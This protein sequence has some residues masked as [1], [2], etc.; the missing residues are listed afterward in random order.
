MWDAANGREERTFKGNDLF[1]NAVAF[2]PDGKFI[3]SGG[4]DDALR[5][6]DAV[7]GQDVHRSAAITAM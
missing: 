3:A 4:D 2:S 1:Q 6:W 7:A 5:I